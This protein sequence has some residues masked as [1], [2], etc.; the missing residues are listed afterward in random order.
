MSAK[1]E[2]TNRDRGATGSGGQLTPLLRVRGPHAAFDPHFLSAIPT[3]TLTFCYPSRPLH[4]VR[5]QLQEKV[6]KLGRKQRSE[7][8][9]VRA[10]VSTL[11]VVFG[12][13]PIVHAIALMWISWLEGRRR[14][15]PPKGDRK[16]RTSERLS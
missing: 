12:D 8:R 2:R 11:N 1:N 15:F 5:H 9:T 10:A 13:Y 16:E 14:K 3:S 6:H 7:R 4:V